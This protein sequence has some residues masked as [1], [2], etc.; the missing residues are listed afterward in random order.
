MRD[1]DRVPPVL[2]VQLPASALSR[3]AECPDLLL[4]HP[5]EDHA[6][7]LLEAGMMP[8]RD[9]ILA[10]PLREGNHR[11]AHPTWNGSTL[12]R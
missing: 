3:G 10:L 8:R 9:A 6:L 11:R 4:G 7:G 1:A 12:C 2:E 5:E